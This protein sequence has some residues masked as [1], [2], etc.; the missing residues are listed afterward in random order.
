MRATVGSRNRLA[1]AAVGPLSP[2]K[3]MRSAFLLKSRMAREVENY[4]RYTGATMELRLPP[5]L[6]AVLR[7][8]PVLRG[9]RVRKTGLRPFRGMPLLNMIMI[10]F[11][12]PELYRSGHPH[13]RLDLCAR[14]EQLA[15]HSYAGR[16]ACNRSQSKNRNGHSKPPIEPYHERTH[17]E[18]EPDQDIEHPSLVA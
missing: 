2:L 9:I 18:G 15:G 11:W 1:D 10:T 8:R 4:L 14:T 5:V 3:A 12:A 6:E 7:P 16:T 13:G 17:G